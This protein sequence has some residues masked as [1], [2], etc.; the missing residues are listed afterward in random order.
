MP[1]LSVPSLSVA[2]LSVGRRIGVCLLVVLLTMG[3][4]TAV[5]IGRVHGMTRPGA[6][7]EP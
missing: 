3:A 2:D 7:V 5:G 1:N 6:P 4:L